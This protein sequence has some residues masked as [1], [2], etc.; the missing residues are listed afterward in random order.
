MCSYADRKFLYLPFQDVSSDVDL[1]L[2]ATASQGLL[3]RYD[4]TTWKGQDRLPTVHART[5]KDVLLN[6]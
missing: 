5:S 3:S 1:R 2:G 6:Y 4:E